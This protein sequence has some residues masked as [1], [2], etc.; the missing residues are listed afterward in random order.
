MGEIPLQGMIAGH[1]EPLPSGVVACANCHLAE[2]PGATGETGGPQL[3]RSTL[4]E[5]RPRR[6]GPPSSF[7]LDSFCRLL[8]VG[9]DPV[10]IVVTRR[11]P[12]YVLKSGQCL[13]LWQYLMETGNEPE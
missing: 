6:H 7:S 3:N 10:Y 1:S 11:M 8:R 12:R 13:A 5:S 9:T 4:T 2:T